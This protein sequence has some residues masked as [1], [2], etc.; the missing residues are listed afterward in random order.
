MKQIKLKRVY[1]PTSKEDGF[2]IL[3]DRLWPRGIKKEDLNVD[4]WLKDVA[5]SSELRKWF[6][7]DPAKWAEFQKKYIHEL[8]E[9]PSSLTPIIDALKKGP[10]TLIYAAHD[11]EHNHALCLKHFIEKRAK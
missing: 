10:V 9:D 6:S 11:T 5:P 2:R 4:L 7:H 3:V 1:D 8:E